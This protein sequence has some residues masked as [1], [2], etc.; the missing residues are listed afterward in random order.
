MQNE[1]MSSWWYYFSWNKS[2][3]LWNFIYYKVT[4][5]LFKLKFKN[6][7]QFH[8]MLKEEFSWKLFCNLVPLISDQGKT[9]GEKLLSAPGH[10]DDLSIC[11]DPERAGPGDS[12]VHIRSRSRPGSHEQTLSLSLRMKPWR[13]PGGKLCI[14]STI[15]TQH[16]GRGYG[17]WVKIMFQRLFLTEHFKLLLLRAIKYLLH[18]L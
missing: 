8:N 13:A 14:H 17:S 15:W 2:R 4:E 9:N 12:H 10:T 11:Q 3:D 18:L 5:F 6:K 7:F 16:N 1:T